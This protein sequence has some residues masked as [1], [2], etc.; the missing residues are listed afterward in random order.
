MRIL[1]EFKI[2]DFKLPKFK[3]KGFSNLDE[4]NYEEI[5]KAG[6]H[7]N[8]KDKDYS[9]T[10]YKTIKEVF[11]KATMEN[12]DKTFILEKFNHKESFKEL[13]YREFRSDVIGFGT[14]LTEYLKIKDTKIVIIG[15]NTYHWYVSY[16][17]LLCG[18][19]IAVPVD[20]ELP[21]NEIENIIKRTKPSAIIY[22]TKKKEVIKKIADRL[23]DVEYFIQMNSDE[24]LNEKSIGLSYL[25]KKGNEIINS[26]NNK[27]ME[28]NIDPEEFKILI[29]T[30]GDRKSTRL[31]SSHL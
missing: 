19:G 26:G 3:I 7:K 14:A 9:P 22:S 4:V 30:S 28:I 1:P 12:L 15:E 13:T 5:K 27:F 20:K 6:E 31:N 17:S 25:I 11:E 10:E 21:E 29:F 23:E 24:E 18:G 2:P 16:M 8:K